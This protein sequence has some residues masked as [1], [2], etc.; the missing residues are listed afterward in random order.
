MQVI[1]FAVGHSEYSLAKTSV[2]IPQLLFITIA[3][4]IRAPY[5][6]STACKNFNRFNNKSDF[7]NI[8]F[9]YVR[10]T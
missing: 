4:I 6:Q 7:C 9:Y 2:T 3:S 5:M 10:C 1:L 8:L